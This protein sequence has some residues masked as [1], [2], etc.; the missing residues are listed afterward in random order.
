MKIV[1]RALVLLLVALL[2]AFWALWLTDSFPE[3]VPPGTNECNDVKIKLE[4]Y[5]AEEKE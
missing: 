1:S 5:P 3:P 2:S 4:M